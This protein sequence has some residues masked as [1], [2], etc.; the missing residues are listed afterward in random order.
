LQDAILDMP[1]ERSCETCWA[2]TSGGQIRKFLGE[3]FQDARF[4]D[5]LKDA[6]LQFKSLSAVGADFYAKRVLMQ[7]A[8]VRAVK[9]HSIVETG[10]ANGVSSAY[11]LLAMERNQIGV[12]RS[13]DINDGSFLPPGKQV[14]WVVPE[15]LRERWKMYLGDSKELLAGIL[16][17]ALPLDVF[18]HDSLHTYE[19]M[20]FEYEVAYPVL[21]PG[22]F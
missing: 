17:D 14:G 7:Y 2:P 1:L 12:L 4:Y 11:V 3:P 9:P 5:L 8:V 21:R 6:E 20:K 19:H 22:G 16:A 15:W 13:I 18:I 10:I